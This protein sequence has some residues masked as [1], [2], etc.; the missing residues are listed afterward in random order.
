MTLVWNLV[1]FIIWLGAIFTIGMVIPVIETGSTT[2]P[3][4]FKNSTD[5]IEIGP[6]PPYASFNSNLSPYATLRIFSPVGAVSSLTQDRIVKSTVPKAD[7][8]RLIK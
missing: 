7:G 3:L 8:V 2:A 1:K 4:A 6:T 5:L